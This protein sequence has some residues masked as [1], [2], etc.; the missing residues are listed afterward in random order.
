MLLALPA[1]DI[2]SIVFA[3]EIHFIIFYEIAKL[4]TIWLKGGKTRVLA[5][6]A[7][8][9]L[10][11]GAW[12]GYGFYNMKHIVRREYVI[13]SEK[14]LNHNYTIAVLSDLHYPTTM[15]KQELAEL[16][17]QIQREQAD[18]VL[19]C[20]DIVDEYTSMKKREEVFS[21]L[22]GL[23]TKSDVF[24]VFGNH[25]TGQYSFQNAISKEELRSLIEAHHIRVLEDEVA[26]VDDKLCLV[27]RD[28]YRMHNRK[29]VATLLSMMPDNCYKIVVDH[30]PRE[31]E[32]SAELK[33]DLHI[34]GHTHAG[35]L[36]PLYYIFECFHLNELNYGKETIA[37]MEAINTSGAGGWGFAIRSDHHSEYVILKLQSTSAS[38]R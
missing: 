12:V 13:Q 8:S 11:A 36:F 27:G 23:C 26:C 9:L 37:Q 34:S 1:W 29:S 15:N 38:N 16:V 7:L 18:I 10:L 19:L 2:H 25:D 28:D 32:K 35:Q 21:L 17:Q 20:G 30:Q 22:E 3:F 14:Q 5:I 4:F 31:L 33:V 6:G 24:Y